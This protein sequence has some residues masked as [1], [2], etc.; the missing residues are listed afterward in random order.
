MPQAQPPTPSSPRPA[1]PAKGSPAATE[2]DDSAPLAGDWGPELLDA[3]LSS[4]NAAA[5]DNLLAAAFAAGADIVPNLETAL[6]DDRTAEFAAQALAFIGGPQA[7]EA[8]SKLT[9]DPRD[10]NLRRFY[11]GALGEFDSPQ[12]NAVLL[13]VIRRADQEPDRTVTEA[14]ILALTTRSE[15][16]LVPQLQQAESRIKDVV[17]RDDLENAVEVLE[18][19]SRYLASAEGQQAGSS[20]EKAVRAYF[21]PALEPGLSRPIAGAASKPAASPRQS[22]TSLRIENLTFSPDRTRALVHAVL[23]SP[24][25]TAYYSLVLQRR[26]GEW[27]TASVWLG[28][29]VE[30]APPEERARPTPR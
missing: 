8:L 27:H 7:L 19:R 23:D 26:Y 1:T 3:I 16:S 6:K 11:Y 13:D 18:T 9:Q 24:V 10:L 17:I 21:A 22:A 25:A 4:A 12:S 30:K 29:E 2:S 15:A 28:S 20:I 5:R 14:A